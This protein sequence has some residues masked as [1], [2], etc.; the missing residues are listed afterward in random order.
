MEALKVTVNGKNYELL[1]APGET[2]SQVLRQRLKLT[3]TKTGCS[4]GS[5]GACTVWADDRPVLSCISPARKFSGAHIT[6]IEGIA[7]GPQLHLLQ[8]K[9]LEKG[10][11]QC[12]FCT[13]GMLMTALAFLRE[14]PT[15]QKSQIRDALAGNLCR[16]TGYKKIIEAVAETA[17]LLREGAEEFVDSPTNEKAGVPQN[18]TI[19]SRQPLIDAS[20]KVTGKAE[21]AAD[22]H[23]HDALVCKLLRS[24]YPHAKLL[25]ID[26]TEAAKIPGVRAI[27]TGRELLEKFGVLPISRDQTAMAVDKVHYIG[28]IVA[29]VAA[30][31]EH[32]AGQALKAIKVH[33]QPL[34]PIFHWSQALQPCKEENLIHPHCA[35]HHC[36]IHKRV[37]MQFGQPETDFK[38]AAHVCEMEFDFPGL[39][40]AFLEPHACLAW[41]DDYQG[42]TMITST[43]VPHYLHRTLSRVLDL[44]LSRVRV[45]KPALGG[46]FGGK[47]DP[48]S[49][50]L[51]VAHLARKTGKPVKL[52]FSREEVFLT[53]HG[54][55]P[56]HLKMK[57]ALNSEGRLSTT[58]ANIIIDGGAFG[59]FGVVTTYY[60]G[61]LLQA[62]YQLK[63]LHFQSTRVYTNKPPS[64]AMRGH[65]AV[66]PRF[67]TEVVI[68]ELARMADTDPCEL[69]L[70]NFL[71]E[72]TLTLGQFRITSNG[73][74]QALR[75]VM[76]QSGWKEKFRKLPYGQGIGA[77]CG[78]YIS[79]SA[80]PIIR[81][82]H[83]QSVVHMK[84]DFDG[85]V[86]IYSGASD[87][88]QGI[89]TVLAM[90]A[91]EV[92]GIG[93]EKT[94]V[95]A[96][97]TLF[98]PVDLGSYSSR[99]TF[100]A[101]N[102]AKMAAENLKNEMAK[103][104][105]QHLGC[106]PAMLSFDNG[107]IKD[108]ESGQSV[109]WEEA[110]IIT[111]NGRGAIS[112]SGYYVCPKLGGN[113]KGAGAG[114]SPSYSF[115]ACIAEVQVD[116]QTGAV[117]VLQ[118]WGA[119]DLGKAL[120]PLAAEGQLE[121]SWHMGMG[122]AL[123]EAM[124]YY[125]GLLLN[126]NLL[127]YKTPT[128]LDSP[129]FQ[130]N[131]IESGDPEGPFGAKECGEGALHP[132]VPAIANAI[133]DAVGVR[134]NSLPITADKILE[135]MQKTALH[136]NTTP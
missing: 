64:G 82:Q 104:V 113:F 93:I 89:D 27:A 24:P 68:D 30:D 31:D 98:T 127:D 14:N 34:K 121:G 6:T 45:I 72:N 35:K 40:H 133:F 136:Q 122:Q 28:E 32:S 129:D 21:Y 124:R 128:A 126:P 42:L 105:A 18:G 19:G 29:A 57:M 43:Q 53:N 76:E 9:F 99:V 116:T 94:Y 23:A 39:N 70:K 110:A 100:M 84:L 88:G 112:S 63:S 78:F 77:G 81:N 13:P 16:C 59:S 11:L 111:T 5:C 46:G 69:R 1:I 118:I 17:S 101:G 2:L 61:V 48:F 52:E 117:S 109:N 135:E 66:N 36:N 44:P 119:H 120:N 86:V 90:I 75:T 38:A 51:I 80:L 134:I 108:L 10:A 130:T 123:T 56:T 83:P 115:G 50:E 25:E 54:R 22:V 15:C 49:H 102:A 73:S 7:R 41:W 4:E 79:G 132:V 60:N 20:A 87:I 107:R 125:N 96:A 114:L 55:H 33:Y 67:A 95:H 58:D 91:A 62:P 47:S 8:Q 26:T 65:G 71:P 103:A 97:D 37:E 12:G 74:R 106:E 3:G 85:R 131:L 92:L